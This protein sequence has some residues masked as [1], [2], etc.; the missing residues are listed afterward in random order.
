[1]FAKRHIFTTVNKII[2]LPCPKVKKFRNVYNNEFILRDLTL[3]GY[4]VFQQR[5]WISAENPEKHRV[6][7]DVLL[8]VGGNRFVSEQ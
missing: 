7:F 6:R 2:Q 5:M 3:L 8:I 4:T 1:M